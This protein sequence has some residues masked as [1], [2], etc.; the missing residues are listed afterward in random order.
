[1]SNLILNTVALQEAYE[2][3]ELLSDLFNYFYEERTNNYK[4]TM[5]KQLGKQLSCYI[6]RKIGQSEMRKLFKR[7][8]KL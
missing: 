8:E 6:G 5:R 2:N 3:N 7:L 1:M 4:E